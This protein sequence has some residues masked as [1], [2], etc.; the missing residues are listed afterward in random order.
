ML[1]REPIYKNS[2]SVMNFVFR[3]GHGP[4]EVMV[5]EE[6]RRGRREGK[7]LN[8]AYLENPAKST[9]VEETADEAVGAKHITALWM[10]A[11]LCLEVRETRL[12][13]RVDHTR[14][15]YCQTA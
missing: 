7:N 5:R 11:T 13:L 10:R 3:K 6:D 8:Y 9:A 12:H 14:A 4:K 1:P 2:E 15:E